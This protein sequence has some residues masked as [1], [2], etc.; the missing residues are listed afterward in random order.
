[1]TN[2]PNMKDFS[3]PAPPP[4]PP[5]PEPESSSWSLC[6]MIFIILNLWIIV[7][8]V[9]AMKF[10]EPLRELIHLLTH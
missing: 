8:G 5:P 7:M 9:I 3:R 10:Q 2:L 1:M 4:P 6:Y